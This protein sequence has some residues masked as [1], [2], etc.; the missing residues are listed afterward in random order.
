MKFKLIGFYIYPDFNESNYFKPYLLETDEIIED[1]KE[2]D[3]IFIGNQVFPNELMDFIDIINTKPTV[4]KIMYIGEPIRKLP[5]C[6]FS[7]VIYNNHLYDAIFG[8]IENNPAKREIKYP[9]Y[10][11]LNNLELSESLFNET[12]QY[13]KETNPFDKK[14]CTLIARHDMGNTRF[15]I[16]QIMNQI[17]Q[18][19]CPSALL[20]NMP[21][22]YLEEKGLIPFLKEYLFNI[23]FENFNNSHKGYITEK[24]MNACLAGTIP[25]Y[26]GE[27]D[28]LD[29][30]IF[31]KK[32]ILFVDK[33]NYDLFI[34]EFLDLLNNP[35]KLLEFYKQDVFMSNA[36]K[37]LEELDNQYKKYIWGFIRDEN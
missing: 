23:C 13:V 29:E 34:K 33:N 4:K 36:Y 25:I 15:P 14:Y 32:R 37:I 6:E 11:F 9:L 21:N 19:D 30:Q 27:L 28:E 3:V 16:Y 31:N 2:A 7:K 12:N 17:A 10:R 8:C 5:H 1:T 26:N 24:L 22:S 20:N 35:N 18:I